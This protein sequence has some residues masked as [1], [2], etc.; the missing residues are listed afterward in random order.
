MKAPLI[1]VIIPTF[2]AAKTLK[3]T[4]DSVI[5]QDYGN[6]EIWLIDGVSTDNTLEIICD[7][8]ASYAYIHWQSEKDKGI[9]DAMNKGIGLAR[10]EWLYFLGADD[11]LYTHD[12]FSKIFGTS[13][14]IA[15]DI[16]YGNAWLASKGQV[17]AGEFSIDRITKENICHQAMFYH[18]RVFEKYPRYIIEYKAFADWYLNMQCFGD[19]TLRIQYIDCIIAN[20]NE[21]GFSAGY[22]DAA[23]RAA[24]DYLIYTQLIHLVTPALKYQLYEE[25]IQQ[26][27]EKIIHKQDVW[28]GIRQIIK[29]GIANKHLITSIKDIVYWLLK[30]S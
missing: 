9:F 27:V 13:L 2:N 10:G 30:S 8:A 24:A 12:V 16:I 29:G 21:Y 1:S 26:G 6:K 15:H 4:L 18:K 28:L 7:Y 17:Y 19:T 20:Y 14:P 3:D 11:V 22:Q 5:N 23:F 25:L